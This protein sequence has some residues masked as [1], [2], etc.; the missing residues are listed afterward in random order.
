MK[1]EVV[2]SVVELKRIPETKFTPCYSP[3]NVLQQIIKFPSLT[4]LIFV[5]CNPKLFR[6]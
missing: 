2:I 5:G 3:T 1:S 6:A 4:V